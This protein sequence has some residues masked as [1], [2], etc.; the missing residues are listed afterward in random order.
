M[1][2]IVLALALLTAA[3]TPAGAGPAV[4]TP[5]KASPRQA[6]AADAAKR[7]AALKAREETARKHEDRA[8]GLA[9][10]ASAKHFK[11]TERE[12]AVE[13]READLKARE[14]PIK[15]GNMWSQVTWPKGDGPH[16]DA[17]VGRKF[18]CVWR[19]DGLECVAAP[20]KAKAK[21]KP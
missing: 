15:R 17:D 8:R 6:A 4:S 3:T 11:V 7:E 12:R 21:A 9:D 16:Y 18:D 2:L 19:Y 20:S 14:K 10:D 5:V 1:T 13:L